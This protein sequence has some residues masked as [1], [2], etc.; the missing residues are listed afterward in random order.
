MRAHRTA[1]SHPRRR[2][3]ALAPLCLLV[4]V[5][6]F[7]LQHGRLAAAQARRTI[8]EAIIEVLEVRPGMVAAEIGAGNGSLAVKLT[9]LVGA[10]GRVYANEI[11]PAMIELITK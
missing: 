9:G 3:A 7:V 6:C 1:L 11:D 4:C 8:E 10:D 5:V 2:R